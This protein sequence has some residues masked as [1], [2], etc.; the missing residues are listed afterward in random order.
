MLL[1]RWLVLFTEANRRHESENYSTK[2]KFDSMK[3]GMVSKVYL[4]AAEVQLNLW[5]LIQS[6]CCFLAAVQMNRIPQGTLATGSTMEK[7]DMERA[8]EGWNEQKDCKH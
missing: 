1:P 7:R 3:N 4:Q 8:A 2:W 5:K 6:S